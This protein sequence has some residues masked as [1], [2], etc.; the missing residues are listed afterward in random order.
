MGSFMIRNLFKAEFSQQT[1]LEKDVTNAIQHFKQDNF[2]EI[3]NPNNNTFQLLEKLE[4][5]Q[6]EDPELF[7]AKKLKQGRLFHIFWMDSK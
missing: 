6:K 4:N 7:I 5:Y 2:H 1:F 3:N